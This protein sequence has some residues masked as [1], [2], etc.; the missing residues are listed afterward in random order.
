MQYEHL[1]QKVTQ[2]YGNTELELEILTV[3]E[4]QEISTICESYQERLSYET[5]ALAKFVWMQTPETLDANRLFIVIHHLAIDGVSWRILIEDIQ[6][7]ITQ[8]E[9]QQELALPNKQTS[10]RQ[11]Q[12]KLIMYA[13]EANVL[14][15]AEYWKG[16]VANTVTLPQD[17]AYYGETTY[18]D[19][20][21]VTTMLGKELTQRLLQEAHQAYSTEIN[22]VLLSALTMTL[23]EWMQQNE[24]VIALEGHGREDLFDDV[25]IS[26]TLGWFTNLYP[27]QLKKHHG[28]E[29]LQ[30]IIANTKEML[31]AI[32][33]KGIGYGVLRYL[34]NDEVLKSNVKCRFSSVLFSII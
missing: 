32:P 7:L 4:E 29:E 25:D 23:T 5:G 14:A 24:I 8:F 19:T 31:R 18:R 34:T 1:D 13:T 26:R 12:Q 15:E 6:T 27:V 16:I 9:N 3:Q 22:D 28:E 21:G 10:Y 17:K 20:H 2:T 11:W 33:N 30:H